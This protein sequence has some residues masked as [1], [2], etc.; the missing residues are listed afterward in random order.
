MSKVNIYIPRTETHHTE[1]YIRKAFRDTAAIEQ[2]VFSPKQ[3]EKGQTYNGAVLIVREWYEPE[4]NSVYNALRADQENKYRHSQKYHWVLT[5]HENKVIEAK[6]TISEDEQE[7]INNNTHLY[8]VRAENHH[9]EEYIRKALKDIVIISQM[10]FVPKKNEK[11]QTYNGVVLLIREW[12]NKTNGMYEML[13]EEKES[14]EDKEPA[15]ESTEELPKEDP[16]KYKFNHS[17]KYHWLISRH[18]IEEP[19]ENEVKESEDMKSEDMKSEDMKSEVKESEEMKSEVKEG[20]NLPPSCGFK[21]GKYLLEGTAYKNALI[22]VISDAIGEDEEFD[23]TI[24]FF[25][26]YYTEQKGITM[27]E[28]LPEITDVCRKAD[29]MEEELKNRCINDYIQWRDNDLPLEIAEG[30]TVIEPEM[31]VFDPPDHDE[32]DEIT[33]Y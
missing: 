21:I 24:I 5:R 13:N 25:D 6:A 9:T 7:V 2:I 4:Y 29:T 14:T 17:P 20:L 32:H 15:K 18:R 26:G 11:G 12:I 19:S 27:A 8:I 1:A 22:R 3:N 10:T 33:F 31:F 28:F 16:P 30:L 23:L